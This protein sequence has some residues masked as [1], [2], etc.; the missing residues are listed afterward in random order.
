MSGG[1]R[2]YLE[3]K[4]QYREIPKKA[5]LLRAGHI[6]R[7]VY[8][9]ESGLFRCFYVKGNTDVCSWFMKEADIIVSI[10]SFF[11]QKESYESI[12]ALEDSCIYYVDYPTLQHIY[13][14]FPEFNFIGRELIQH[15]YILWAQQLYGLRMQNSAERFQWLM[16][17]HPELF[18]RVP[19]K[20][21]ASYLGIT[22]VTLSKLKSLQ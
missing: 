15:Y 6:C 20:Y 17:N 9:I 4:L 21:L 19:A 8:F 12:Q 2:Q 22:D 1:L 16:Q 11:R 13:K 14:E 7:N 5:F 18:L 10:E 3:E